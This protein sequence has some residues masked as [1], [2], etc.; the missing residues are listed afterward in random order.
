M[1]TL[2]KAAVINQL[3]QR[4]LLYQLKNVSVFEIQSIQRFEIFNFLNWIV[5]QK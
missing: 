5:K 4:G 2:S 1:L 3:A